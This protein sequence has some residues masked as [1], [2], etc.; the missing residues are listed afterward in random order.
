MNT[1]VAVV[2]WNGGRHVA[3]CLESLLAQTCSPDVLVLDNAS[4]DDTVDIAR[5]LGGRATS[6]ARR[7]DVIVQPV[8]LGYTR[9]ANAALHALLADATYDLVCLVNQD[10]TLAADWVDTMRA[11][12]AAS[13]QAGAVGSKVFYPDGIT[14]QHAGGY[15]TQ[16]RLVGLHAGHHERDD[17]R[18]DV[19]RD[20]DFVTGA[21][22]ALRTACLREVGLFDELFSPGYYDDVDLCARM[23]ARGWRVLY[24]P[25][26]RACHVESAS[27]TDMFERLRLTHRNRLIFAADRLAGREFRASFAD[28]ERR[29]LVTE[30]LDVLRALGAAYLDVALRLDEI[31]ARRLRPDGSGPAT[32]EALAELCLDLRACCLGE[33]GARR[34]HALREALG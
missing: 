2:T 23:W 1:A 24:T 32:H 22:V 10:A 6:R 29:A 11:C 8:N 19:E 21:A 18:F 25:R 5:A 17:G 12:F 31:R 7:L 20:V 27:F 30:P 14:L 3:P 34:T 15:L 4:T 33:I 16:P 9:G 13:P 26:A 28:A